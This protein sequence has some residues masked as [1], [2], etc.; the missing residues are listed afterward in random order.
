MSDPSILI[1]EAQSKA[2]Q[3]VARTTGA[4][5]PLVEKAG[6]YI[7]WVLGT[8]PA[9]LVGVLGGD[10][11]GHVRIRNLARYEQRTREILQGRGVIEP[12]PVSP[13][14]AIPL[15]RAAADESREVLQELWARL[16]AASM[17]TERRDGVR[18][19]FLEAVKAMDLMDVRLLDQLHNNN[20]RQGIIIGNGD[21]HTIGIGVLATSLGA[22]YDDVDVSVQHLHE[23]SFLF[24]TNDLAGRNTWFQSAKLREFMRVCY[25]KR[26]D[27]P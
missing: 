22:R 25:S 24:V 17:D 7:G 6:S 16:L 12:Q 14:L 8:L 27:E 3:E 2:I 23:L 15:L 19:S 18:Y 10:W 4:A 20:I 13:S 9:D 5:L 26:S 21:Q 11:L 1:G